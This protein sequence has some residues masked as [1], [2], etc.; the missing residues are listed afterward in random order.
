MHSIT[1]PAVSLEEGKFCPMAMADMNAPPPATK[2]R[3]EIGFIDIL[4]VGSV[5]RMTQ[6]LQCTEPAK[7]IL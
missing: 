4:L 5:E 1:S 6:E 3:R 7:L 2:S